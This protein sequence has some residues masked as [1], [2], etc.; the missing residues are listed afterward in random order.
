MRLECRGPPSRAA[1]RQRLERAQ[2]VGDDV[3]LPRLG[4]LGRFRGFVPRQR[5]HGVDLP[6]ELVGGGLQL[7]EIGTQ[8]LLGV[9][10]QVL[11]QKLAVPLDGVERRA[12]VVTQPPVKGF[13]RFVRPGDRTT[14]PGSGFSRT[15]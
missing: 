3:K 4:G 10:L 9:R 2:H 14:N 6:E 11:D 7:G 15:R 5:G 8:R 12:Q 1:R 13:E